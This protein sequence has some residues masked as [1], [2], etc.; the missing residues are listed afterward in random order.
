M[1]KKKQSSQG[2]T[3]Q[4]NTKAG[5]QKQLGTKGNI[6]VRRPPRHQGR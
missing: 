6:V 2:K 3:R 5:T 4:P 1:P